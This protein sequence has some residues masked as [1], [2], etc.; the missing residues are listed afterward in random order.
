[1]Q[2]NLEIISHFAFPPWA[3]EVPYLVNITQSDRDV[4]LLHQHEIETMNPKS[5]TRIYTDAS[6]TK[7]ST[8]VGVAIIAI[9]NDGKFEHK[10]TRNI[11]TEAIVYNSEFEVIAM[12]VEFADLRTGFG[13]RYHIYSDSQA[14]LYRLKQPSD[15]HGQQCQLR[16]IAACYNINQRVSSL[17]IHSLPCHN[18]IEVNSKADKIAKDASLKTPDITSTTFAML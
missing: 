13:H 14:A 8:G 9:G 3:S 16:V 4:I 1:M 11:G 17:H 15:R 18:E 10:E 6:M 12:A 5:S 2:Q 7:D